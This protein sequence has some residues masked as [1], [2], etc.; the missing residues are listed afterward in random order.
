MNYFKEGAIALLVLL[1]HEDTR[2]PISCC[3]SIGATY[4]G[5]I[6]CMGPSD[7]PSHT[8]LYTEATITHAIDTTTTSTTAEATRCM[9]SA[10]LLVPMI[11]VAMIVYI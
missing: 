3:A 4:K 9:R 8:T 1:L 5:R 7:Y 2:H 6:D 11:A 10:F